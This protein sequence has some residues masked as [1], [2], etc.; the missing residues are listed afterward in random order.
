MLLLHGRDELGRA[1][2]SRRTRP[3]R[4][5]CRFRSV[6]FTQG[7]IR[8]N[9]AR[10]QRIWKGQTMATSSQRLAPA[11]GCGGGWAHASPPPSSE[12]RGACARPR[13][14]GLRGG[15]SQE[16]L[17]RCRCEVS[18]VTPATRSWSPTGRVRRSPSRSRSRAPADIFHLGRP[19]LDGLRGRAQA[20]Q[21][22]ARGSICWGTVARAHCAG[23]QPD[24]SDHRARISRSR[25]HRSDRLAM[26]EPYGSVPASKYGKAALE[27]LGVWGSVS[28]ARSL[29]RRF[30]SAPPCFWCRAARRPWASSTRPMRRVR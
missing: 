21:A 7:H 9:I 20:H 24:Q 25:R 26:A 22:G 30:P 23:R 14:P 19:R 8:S 10:P 27:A 29:W 3:E 18:A 5:A 28:R 2:G 11:A 1:I 16:R 12:H 13:P 6:P 4:S 15:Q 17:G